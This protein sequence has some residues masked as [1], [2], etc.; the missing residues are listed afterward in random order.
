MIGDER[1]GTGRI[2]G[3]GDGCPTTPISSTSHLPI[4][5]GSTVGPRSQPSN[6]S[7]PSVNR[8]SSTMC[9]ARSRSPAPKSWS[10]CRHP[11]RE[12]PRSCPSVSVRLW[13][14]S[15]RSASRIRPIPGF[16]AWT[17]RHAGETLLVENE[18][19]LRAAIVDDLLGRAV[20]KRADRYPPSQRTSHPERDEPHRDDRE[21]NSHPAKHRHHVTRTTPPNAQRCSNAATIMTSPTRET[22]ARS[23][24]ATTFK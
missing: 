20:L 2:S 12:I 13:R 3:G 10:R 22:L 18:P 5:G 24:G 9:W 19:R 16:V 6:S 14:P 7:L 23:K 15:R 17:H 11:S 4:V 1:S 21:R 8:I